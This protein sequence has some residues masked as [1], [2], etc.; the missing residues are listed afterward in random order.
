MK[1][2]VAIMMAMLMVMSVTVVLA[3]GVA[4]TKEKQ[5]EKV[6]VIIMF[7][8]KT[9]KDLI[10][11]HG[12]EIKSVYQIKPAV[13]ASLPQKAIYALK[14]NPKIAFIV[15]DLEIFTMAETLDWGVD[16]I[17]ADIVHEYNRGTGVKVAI[18]DTGIDYD[19]LDLA[20]NYKDGKVETM[21]IQWINRDTAHTVRAL[22]LR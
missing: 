4:T 2:I 12:G 8:D 5:S 21:M 14:K 19:H 18:M 11:Q 15:P 10:K 9:D 17:D 3:S 6:P 16:R 1:K 7:K 13:A 20:A 22:L